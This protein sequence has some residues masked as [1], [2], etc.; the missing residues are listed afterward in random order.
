[1]LV[2]LSWVALA[3]KK[4]QHSLLQSSSITFKH[5]HF[6]RSECQSLRVTLKRG[7]TGKLKATTISV[8]FL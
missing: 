5:I 1:M 6:L 8:A 2:L 4:H 3:S 7:A